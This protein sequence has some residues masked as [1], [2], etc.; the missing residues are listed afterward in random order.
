MKTTGKKA[1]R[2][3]LLP[4]DFQL[5]SRR[6]FHYGLKLAAVTG[7]RLEILHVIKTGSESAFIAP[8]RRQL[9]ARKT[10]AL[11]ELGRLMRLAKEAGVRSHPSLR[12]GVPDACILE[13]LD[14]LRPEMIVMGTEGRTGWDR[15]RLGSTAQAVVRVATCPVLAVHSGLAGDAVHHHARVKLERWLLPTDFSS[16]AEEARRAVSVAA[17]WTTGRISVIHAAENEQAVKRANQ[18]LNGLIAD[19][20][21]NGLEAEGLCQ[22][23]DPLEAILSHAAQW[24]ADVIAVGTQ[25]RRGLARLLL[26]SVAEGLLRRAGCPVLI[27]RNAAPLV[28]TAGRHA[29]R[30]TD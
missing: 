11:L 10:A 20:R 2:S 12:F 14:R 29:R 5:A 6:A 22:S 30:H 1:A 9:N 17:Q 25:G 3:I 15:L 24:R 4:T 21:R 8:D 26:G 27:V 7:A 16:S 19:F 18:K 28:R 23:G 13:V